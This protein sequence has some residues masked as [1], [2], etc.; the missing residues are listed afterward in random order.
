MPVLN[1]LEVDQHLEML[2]GAYEMCILERPFLIGVLASYMPIENTLS[3]LDSL[4][5]AVEPDSP[6]WR[7]LLHAMHE[8]LGP[9]QWLRVV[10]RFEDVLPTSLMVVPSAH[11]RGT[12]GAAASALQNSSVWLGARSPRVRKVRTLPLAP[13]PSRAKAMVM[14]AKWYQ[15]V[16]LKTRVN[17]ISSRSV[18]RA[19][20][21]TPR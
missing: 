18:A 10:R 4:L 1:G 2:R 7:N 21:K 20:R 6:E 15:M 5:H 19:V 17:V 11:R 8:Y 9:E 13:K 16:K 14:K 12:I 3:L